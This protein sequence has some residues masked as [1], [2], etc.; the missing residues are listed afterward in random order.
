MTADN[1]RSAFSGESQASMRYEIWGQLAKKD[2]F[3]NIARLFQATADAE[4]V[5][6]TLH[7][8][9]L[10]EE[11]GDFPVNAMAGFGIGTIVE[12]LEAA[13]GG[14]EYEY[15]EMYPAFIAVAELNEEDDALK[16]FRFAVEAEK[17]HAQRYA[18]AIVEAEKG[19]DIDVETVYLCPVCGYIGYNADEE[20]CPLC[21]VKS[22]LF[23]EY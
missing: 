5:H 7:F 18:D 1:L 12:N 8:N 14:E 15:K 4:K 22:S 17:V 6:A 10:K 9:A 23:I 21:G 2:G 13:K 20:N 11:K 19:N 16:A 3:D